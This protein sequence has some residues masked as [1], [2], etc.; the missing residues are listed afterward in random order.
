MI[1]RISAIAILGLLLTS[2]SNFDHHAND[3]TS[4]IQPAFVNQTS[5][6]ME[7][8]QQEWSL[9]QQQIATTPFA[10]SLNS[11]A[12]HAPDPRALNVQPHGV[13]VVSVPD[14]PI[15]QLVLID[16]RWATHTDPSGTIM[17][18]GRTAFSCTNVNANTVFVA[19]SMVP[20]ACQYEFEIIILNSLGYDVSQM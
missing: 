12:L 3:A 6:T 4:P 16:P 5:A 15:S 11:S 1:R 8:L 17:C 7:Q 9:A 10:L 14:V 20:G 19:A 18:D 13:T 2:C